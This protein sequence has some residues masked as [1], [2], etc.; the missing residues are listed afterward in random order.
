[1]P[2]FTSKKSESERFKANTPE[3]MAQRVREDPMEKAL[4]LLRVWVPEKRRDEVTEETV[5]EV[6]KM[7]EKEAVRR[8]GWMRPG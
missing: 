2:S 1:M 6:R 5:G 8:R 7:S 4:T 3:W